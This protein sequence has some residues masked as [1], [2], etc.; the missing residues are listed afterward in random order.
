MPSTA[1]PNDLSPSP[2]NRRRQRIIVTIAVLALA[3]WIGLCWS[4]SPVLY[5]ALRGTWRLR[6]PGS[7]LR[8]E[9]VFGDEGQLATISYRDTA[10]IPGPPMQWKFEGGLLSVWR[11]SDANVAAQ[12]RIALADQRKLMLQPIDE[13]APPLEFWRDGGTE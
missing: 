9:W 8:Q 11:R 12:Y 1:S 13:R 3:L 6:R 7:T 10:A 2:P 4:T 5:S